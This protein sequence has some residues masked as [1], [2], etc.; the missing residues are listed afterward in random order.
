MDPAL[1]IVKVSTVTVNLCR[2]LLPFLSTLGGLGNSESF[3]LEAGRILLRI[4][5]QVSGMYWDCGAGVELPL[6]IV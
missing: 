6:A 1:S 3:I 5:N 2:P 4:S